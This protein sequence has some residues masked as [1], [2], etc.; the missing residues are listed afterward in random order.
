MVVNVD[1]SP[2][3]LPLLADS[4]RTPFPHQGRPPR[5]PPPSPSLLLANGSAWEGGHHLQ[6][7][8]ITQM[9]L[10]SWF[11]ISSVSVHG[12][13]KKFKRDSMSLVDLSR[14][15]QKKCI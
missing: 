12:T 11:G 15:K 7:T 4:V 14:E 1:N 6:Y 3:F 10:F 2:K 13:R 9:G 8:E 5:P